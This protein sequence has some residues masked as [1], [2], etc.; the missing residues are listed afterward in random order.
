MDYLPLVAI[1]AL[2][3]GLVGMGVHFA[4]AQFA[5]KK[6]A[7]QFPFEHF[8]DDELVAEK[9]HCDAY[10]AGNFSW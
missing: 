9:R 8:D 3:F 7:E 2:M 4:L 1:A 5:R 6:R 10:S